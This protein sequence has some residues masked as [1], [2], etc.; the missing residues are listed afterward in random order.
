MN[1]G[2]SQPSRKNEKHA[3]YVY[4]RDV[5]FEHRGYAFSSHEEAVKGMTGNYASG[6]LSEHC[7]ESYDVS[8]RN[9]VKSVTAIETRQF[10]AS[11]WHATA[12]V[13]GYCRILNFHNNYDSIPN[14]PS[15][16][17]GQSD[18]AVRDMY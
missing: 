17:S 15:E 5:P 13:S 12:Y 10:S 18:C 7:K 16:R 3:K 8:F 2:G 9:G 4:V 14:C 11:F 1:G 6:A